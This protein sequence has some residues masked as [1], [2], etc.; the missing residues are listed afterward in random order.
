MRLPFRSALLV[1]AAVPAVVLALL[2]VPT[3]VDVGLT[4]LSRWAFGPAGEVGGPMWWALED[5][6]NAILF[7]P[8]GVLLAR[9]VGP[10]PAVV[11]AGAVSGG[12][13]FLQGFIPQRNP[14]LVDVVSN[15]TGAAVGVL[16]AILL[17][18]R[19]RPAASGDLALTAVRARP[20]E[21][22]SRG[23]GHLHPVQAGRTVRHVEAGLVEGAVGGGQHGV[24]VVPGSAAHGAMFAQ[25]SDHARREAVPVG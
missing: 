16:V 17:A 5:A 8:L 3:H 15:T 1:A 19:R 14:D 7:L 23:L 2:L 13:E 22:A 6:A 24:V 21:P 20:V 10:L 12:C 11:L 25:P 9:R 4:Q 18:H